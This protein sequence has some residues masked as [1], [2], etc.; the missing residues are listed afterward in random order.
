MCWP[1]V[2]SIDC[3]GMELFAMLLINIGVPMDFTIFLLQCSCTNG[4]EVYID[5]SANCIHGG[6]EGREL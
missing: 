6:K 5:F 4:L 3:G 1:S 2:T